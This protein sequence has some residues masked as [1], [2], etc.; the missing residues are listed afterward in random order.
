MPLFTKLASLPK[1]TLQKYMRPEIFH[2]LGWSLGVE[3][4]HGKYDVSKGSYYFNVCRDNPTDIPEDVKHHY[5][6]DEIK[7]NVG[8]KWIE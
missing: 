5:T 2:S 3:K 1:E 7:M 4:F 6:E 8:N